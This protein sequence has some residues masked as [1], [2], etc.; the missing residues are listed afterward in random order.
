MAKHILSCI[1]LVNMVFYAH[2]GVLKEEHA[3]GA[4]YEVDTDLHFDFSLAASEDNLKKTID[5][6]E[7]YKKI[8]AILTEKNYFLI[9]TIAFDIAHEFFLAF[10]ILDE[11][12]VKVRKRNPPING[13]C[14][15]A[16]AVYTERRS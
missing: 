6:G 14:D 13:I 15:F 7:A 10:P 5:Y 1:R 12:T 4:K 9:E 2:H 8:K 3:I 16:E 11:I